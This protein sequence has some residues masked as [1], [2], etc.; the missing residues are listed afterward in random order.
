MAQPPYPPQPGPWLPPPSP[1]GSAPDPSPYGTA[2]SPS[3]YGYAPPGWPPGPPPPRRLSRG[4]VAWIVAGSV[5][6]VGLLVAVVMGARHLGA[7]DGLV[8]S[9]AVATGEPAAPTALGDDPVLDEHALRCHD[10]V[11]SV[12]DE[13]YALSPLGSTYEQYGLTCGGRVKAHEVSACTDLGG[14]VATSSPS[15]PAGLGDDPGLDGYAQRCH[16]GLFQA[17]DDL[18][19]LSAPMS[20]YER[21]GLTCGGRVEP[22]AVAYCTDLEGD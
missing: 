6:A 18:Y 2:P 22:Y 1:Y 16:D 14:A 19:S 8:P 21:Y 17:C 10:G 7:Q 5:L 9:G 20:D 4:T 3:P 11:M 13:L 12:C 15:S